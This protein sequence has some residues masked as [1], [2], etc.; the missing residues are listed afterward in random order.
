MIREGVGDGN[1]VNTG[2][3]SGIASKAAA[4]RQLGSGRPDIV[5]SKK[6]LKETEE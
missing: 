4:N 2:N 6:R 5:K 3:R 1:R